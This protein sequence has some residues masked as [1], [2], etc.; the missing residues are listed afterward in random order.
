MDTDRDTSKTPI[1]SPGILVL[2]WLTYAFWGWTILALTLLTAISV[3]FFLNRSDYDSGDSISYALAAVIVLFVISVI[4]DVLYAKKEPLHKQGAAMVIM[5]IHAVIFAL[6]G[7]GALIVAVFAIVNLL[8]GAGSDGNE[9]AKTALITGGL[10]AVVYGVTL[11]RTVRPFKLNKVSLLYSL[12]MAV[13][14]IVVTILGVVG[15]TLYAS[16][17]KDDR[18][19]ERGLSDV[20]QGVRNYTNK[21]GALPSSLSDLRDSNVS[22]DAREL[23]DRNMVEYKTGAAV[24]QP[25]VD[26]NLGTSLEQLKEPAYEY[27]LCVTYKSDKGGDYAYDYVEKGRDVTPNTYSHGEGR[28]CYELATKYVYPSEY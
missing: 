21:N 8:I 25:N 3:S 22:S 6:C 24:K 14:T 12:F 27:T 4:C 13:V 15:P 9:G 28:T 20:S 26:N 23:I 7:I 2:Q 16:Q 18:L 11:L 17:T 1:N 5:I 10:I 19:I